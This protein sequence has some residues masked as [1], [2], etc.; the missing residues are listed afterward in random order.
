MH[1]SLAR[2]VLAHDR[3][4]PDAPALLWNGTTLTYGDLAA[5]ADT[6]AV[7]LA[8]PEL[9][10]DAPLA[11][12]AVKSPASLALVLA[13]LLARRTVLLLSPDLGRLAAAR[14]AE[15]AGCV[16]LLVPG[17][18]GE[19]AIEPVRAPAR[20]APPG[21]ALLL[22]TS[23]STRLPKTVC[24]SHTAL[25]RFTRW[26]GSAFPLGTGHRV[27]SYAPLN[28][29]LSLFDVWATLRHGGCVIPV[30][31]GR[32]ADPRHLAGLLRETGPEVVQAVPTLFR[33]LAGAGTDAEPFT[34]VR[35][36][37]LTGEHTPRSLRG[38]LARLFPRAEF[39]NVYGCTE[40]NDSLLYSC[41]AR[42]AAE[43]AT[44]PLGGPLPGAR[45]RLVDGGRELTG[46][47]TGELVVHT[48]FQADGYL[49]SDDP[50]DRFVRPAPGT[51]EPV[52]FR[53]GDLVRRDSE[54]RLTL[55]G[56]D[57]FQVKVGGVR[58][59]PE[60]VEQ[61][62]QSHPEVMEAAVVALAAPGPGIRLHALVRVAP[63]CAVT[64]L[65]LL[66]HCSAWLPRAAVPTVH[67]TREPLPTGITGKV[68]R[69]QVRSVL[70]ARQHARPDRPT[71]PES[72]A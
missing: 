44:L 33:L 70:T 28:F 64:G 61:V 63:D 23:G 17:A 40:T 49:G 66:T 30:D 3:R 2:D 48:P 5:L 34:S 15:H 72:S 58:V 65:H 60:A 6:A 39:H 22:T 11:V 67:L 71:Q 36:V 27:L 38:R 19:T 43:P 25:D 69:A 16:G 46:P 7:R 20:P 1:D 55:V 68:D 21:S 32:A 52:W 56:R 42:E 9:H 54:G 47:G 24:L 14:L 57:D 10:G 35:H 8:E 12:R 41:G 50:D 37:L 29:D 31:P 62:A 26:A 4:T 51:S 59:S 45:V 18:D 53:T 13:C